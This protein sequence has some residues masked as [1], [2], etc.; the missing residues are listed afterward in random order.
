[1]VTDK[2]PPQNIDAEES[3]LGGILLD[4]TAISRIAD[5]LPAEAFYVP[6]HQEIYQATLNLYQNKKPTDFMTVTSWL[7]D[8]EL[9]DKVGGL[10]KITQLIERTVSAVNI[11]R[12]AELVLDKYQRRRLIYAGHEIIDL[13]YDTMTELKSLLEQSEEK[14][15][16]LTTDKTDNFQPETIKD[17]LKM[18]VREMEKGESTGYSTGIP[19]L[20][21]LIGR[22]TKQDLII[23]AGRASMG[24]TWLA[25]YLGNYLAVTY[26][27]PVVFF[28][29]EMSK[30][31]LTK[32]FLAIHTGIDSARLK[33]NLIY[34]EEYEALEQGLKGLMALPIIIDDTPAT[35]LTPSRMRSVLR[36]IQ[37]EKGKIGLVVMDYIQKL[38]D[39]AAGNRAQAIGQYSG[40]FKDMAKEFDVP[41][42]A[43]A[44]INRSVEAKNDK[45]PFISELKDSGDLEQDADV[46]LLLYRD[47]YYNSNSKDKGIMEI[48]VGK[49]R[50]GATGICQVKFNP[51]IGTFE[52]LYSAPLG[53]DKKETVS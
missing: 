7:K 52:P 11:D 49:S 28:S 51:M 48:N 43:L 5:M 29:A 44:Q 18:V 6:S 19:D 50:D 15:F 40:A 46:A 35:Q 9:L 34:D 8:H 20:D 37:L 2:L 3:I 53:Y 21:K 33:R 39:R 10:A 26:Q 42:I 36:R 24:K 4:E 30:S 47:E 22:L 16:K 13:G 12:Y 23:I 45:R 1:M 32:R 27:L 38:G 17:C 41:L 31:Q 25:I 14:V